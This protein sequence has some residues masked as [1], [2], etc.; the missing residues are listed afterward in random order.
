MRACPLVER[1]GPAMIT[2]LASVAA[3]AQGAPATA[4]DLKEPL[5]TITLPLRRLGIGA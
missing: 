4:V 5:S 1:F 3:P 2:L